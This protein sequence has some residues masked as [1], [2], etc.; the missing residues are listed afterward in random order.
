M[1]YLVRGSQ[2]NN[3]MQLQNTRNVSKILHQKENQ[4]TEYTITR[5]MKQIAGSTFQTL[6]LAVN[7]PS[8]MGKSINKKVRTFLIIN[9]HRKKT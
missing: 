9:Y 5:S 4:Q 3:K 6:T 7:K 8:Q 2:T 1:L